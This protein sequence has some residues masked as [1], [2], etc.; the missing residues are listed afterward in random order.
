MA[1][2][3][4]VEANQSREQ[5]QV[6]FGETVT[7][8]V[9][10]TTEALFEAVERREQF[11]E[12]LLVSRLG[13]GEAAAIDPIVD[14]IVN[15]SIGLVDFAA[16]R[17]RVKV[18]RRLAEFIEFRV[19]HSYDLGRFIIDDRARL[20]VPQYRD[21]GA[22]GEVRARSAVYLMDMENAVNRP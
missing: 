8:Q 1:V 9:A 5:P 22:A 3:D 21:S 11:A 10:L 18:E 4:C 19:Q 13:S 6:G 14:R 15:K 20:A 2:I 16:Q 12:A 17:R 7:Y